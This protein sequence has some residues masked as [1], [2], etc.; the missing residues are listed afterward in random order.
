MKVRVGV[1]ED[2]SNFTF[3]K[4]SV[5]KGDNMNKTIL[6][7]VLSGVGVLLA[8]VGSSL[9]M[10]AGLLALCLNY[11]IEIGFFNYDDEKN[12]KVAEL[13]RKAII[14]MSHVSKVLGITSVVLA[15]VNLI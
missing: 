12:P 4:I 13:L 15:L 8:A 1:L 3:L 14:G 9:G 11:H 7:P 6:A 5:F 10:A 2:K